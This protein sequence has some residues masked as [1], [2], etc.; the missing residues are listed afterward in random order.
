MKATVIKKILTELS[1]ANIGEGNIMVNADGRAYCYNPRQEES[2]E[3]W[4]V[5]DA[6]NILCLE[7]SSGTHWIDCDCVTS[8][9][10]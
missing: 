5:D 3:T 9:E 8:I 2:G 6:D 10:I 4:S 7:L 1:T